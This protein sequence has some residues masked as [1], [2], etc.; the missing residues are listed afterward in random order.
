MRGRLQLTNPVAMLT[1]SLSDNDISLNNRFFFSK[2]LNDMEG[3]LFSP[4]RMRST[5]ILLCLFKQS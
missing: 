4:V 5:V 1:F 2:S 3:A